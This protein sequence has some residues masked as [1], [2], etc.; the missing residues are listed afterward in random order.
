MES[1]GFLEHLNLFSGTPSLLC[2]HSSYTAGEEGNTESRQ[3]FNSV[4]VMGSPE[5]QGFPIPGK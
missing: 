5:E 3:E 2:P 1:V 4:G